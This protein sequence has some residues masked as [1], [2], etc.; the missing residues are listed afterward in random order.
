MS[1]DGDKWQTVFYSPSLHYE[2]VNMLLGLTNAPTVFQA[3]INNVLCDFL[4]QFVFI[5]LDDILIFSKSEE[6]HVGHLRQVSLAPGSKHTNLFHFTFDKLQ[7]LPECF[8]TSTFNSSHLKTF[9][10]D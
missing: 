10:Q 9:T 1:R 3:L 6:E 4:N 8:N 5:Y 2:Y 7:L